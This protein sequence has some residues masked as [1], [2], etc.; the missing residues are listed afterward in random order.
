MKEC[1]NLVEISTPNFIVFLQN[2]RKYSKFCKP[3]KMDKNYYFKN[4]KNENSYFSQCYTVKILY[5]K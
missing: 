4:L 1:S 2:W 5:I 3:M